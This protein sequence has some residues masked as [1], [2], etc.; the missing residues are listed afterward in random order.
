MLSVIFVLGFIADPIINFA[1]DPYG[2]LLPGFF[3]PG[4][5]FQVFTFGDP[6]L[7]Y[8]TPAPARPRDRQR[9]QSGWIEHFT[10]GAASLGL[11]SFLKFMFTSPLQFFFR[12]GAGGGRQTGRDR[13]NTVTW[14]MI[15]IGVATFLYVSYP[16][17]CSSSANCSQILPILKA[18]H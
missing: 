4:F 6:G 17:M 16:L 7:Y 3:V 9:E 13:L 5:S 11:V 2:T 18:I 14:I 10:K 8:D 15:V 12:G 1:L